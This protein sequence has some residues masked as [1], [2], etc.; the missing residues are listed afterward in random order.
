MPC[1]GA[2]RHVHEHRV[3]APVLGQHVVLRQI[4]PD[5][6]G[7]RIALVDLGDR[8][9][10]R[11][12]RRARVLN[13]FDRLRHDAVVGRDDQ[14]DDVRD[15]RAARTHRGERRVARRIE[16]RD[17]A[18]RRLDV[19]RADV[20]RD[21]ARLAR[22][23]LGATDVV[24]QRGLAVVDVTHDGHDRRT[25]REL[26]LRHRSVC[27]SSSI[28][29]SLTTHG[30][31]AELLD[32]EHRGVLIDGLIDRRHHAHVHHDL[33]DFVGLH[34]HALRQ[35]GDRDRLADLHVALDGRGRTLEAVL[36]S[37]R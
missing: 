27:S 17:D 20:L 16:E 35:L 10:D 6:V 3:A 1:A 13:R 15:L 37:R 2:R 8:D 21:A 22:R 32:H 29:L 31:V 14:H 5:L 19:I 34:G 11:H 4:V 28:A 36:A 26:V 25:R 7:I 18:L 9:D 33:D 30:G 23:D 12:F 24:E